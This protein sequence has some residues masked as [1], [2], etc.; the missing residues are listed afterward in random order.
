M[1]S[2]VAIVGLFVVTAAAACGSNSGLENGG[3]RCASACPDGYVCGEDNRCWPVG[4]PDV[5][6]TSAGGSGGL[7]GGGDAGA[8]DAPG[9]EPDVPIAVSVGGAGGIIAVGGSVAG[10]T[11]FIGGTGGTTGWL[12]G[13]MSTGGGIAT[14]GTGGV[15]RGI[16][17]GVAGA[18]S[19]GNGGVL[20]SVGTDCGIKTANLTRQ[21]AD[22]LLVLD[23]SGSLTSAMD[24]SSACAAGSITCQQRW[25]TIVSGLDGVLSGSSGDVNW[26]LQLFNSDGACGV[27]TAPE[28]P[29]APGSA[30]TIQAI[31]AGVTPNGSTPTRT[32]V[33]AAVTYV[34]NLADTNGKYILLATDGEPNCLNGSGGSA[35]ASDVAGTVAAITAAAAAGIKVYVI[36]VGPETGNLDNFA[37]AGGTDHYYPALSPQDLNAALATIVGTVASC[38]FNL[39]KAPKDPTNVAVQ[40]NGDKGLRAPQDPTHTNGWDYTSST[41]TTIQLYGSWCDNVTNGTYA[42]A[43]ALMGCPGTPFH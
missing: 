31:I 33:N 40:F 32:A 39:G 35:G 9:A 7:G 24:S 21:P 38:T 11:V 42:S 14:G 28:V 18:G 41:N 23:R 25:A 34:Q 8:P 10:G 37:Q 5:G 29:V 4:T 2:L 22:L 17:A 36:G 16:D 20:G 15:E 26:G 1:R 43:E 19:G 6:G 30:A 27:A 12:G 3:L 13:A